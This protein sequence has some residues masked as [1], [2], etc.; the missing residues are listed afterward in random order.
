M[1]FDRQFTNKPVPVLSP[2]RLQTHG[3]GAT[4]S[5]ENLIE[6]FTFTVDVQ[7]TPTFQLE[8]G[9]IIN[10]LVENIATWTTTAKGS[11]T[12][13]ITKAVEEIC[14]DML[15]E[16]IK[17]CAAVFLY[18]AWKLPPPHPATRSHPTKK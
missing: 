13:M 12:A 16:W 2:Q 6:G 18:S 17:M 4:P 15:I 1:Q 5:A 8:M 3:F 9:R 7:W 10:L 11:M 14:N